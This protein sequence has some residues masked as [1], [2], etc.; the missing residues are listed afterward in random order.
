MVI[1]PENGKDDKAT[2]TIIFAFSIQ[3]KFRYG[4]EKKPRKQK[5]DGFQQETAELVE[6]L[7]NCQRTNQYRWMPDQPFSK[8]QIFN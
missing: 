8:A 7:R 2:L 6:D 5:R 4:V 3:N 1:S